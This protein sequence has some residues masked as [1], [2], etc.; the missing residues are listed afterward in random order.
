VNHCL[1]LAK[2][3]ITPGQKYMRKRPNVR[4][5]KGFGSI[6]CVHVPKKERKKSKS[7]TRACLFLRY[8]DFIKTCRVYEVEMRKILITR[9]VVFD[10]I[11][12]SYHHF[13]VW[14]SVDKNLFDFNASFTF[15]CPK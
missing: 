15:E 1:T 7:K 13:K 4:N 8:N 11:Q 14:S 12:S 3:E 10:E 5:F 6:C 2:K 9:D